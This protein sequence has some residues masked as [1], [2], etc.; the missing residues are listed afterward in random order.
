MKARLWAR[1]DRAG[2]VE[3]AS[4]GRLNHAIVLGTQQ[5]RQQTVERHTSPVLPVHGHDNLVVHPAT[6]QLFQDP[7]KMIRRHAEH[8]RTQTTEPVERDDRPFRRQ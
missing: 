1:D 8:R 7:Q 5:D 4:L 3:A 6:N 2:I